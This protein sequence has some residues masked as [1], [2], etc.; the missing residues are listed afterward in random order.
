[1]RDARMSS[2][3]IKSIS[4]LC[5][6]HTYKTITCGENIDSC[7]KGSDPRI[8]TISWEDEEYEYVWY[9]ARVEHIALIQHDDGVEL[10][11]RTEGERDITHIYVY[12][13]PHYNDNTKYISIPLVWDAKSGEKASNQWDA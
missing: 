9:R 11:I 3:Q 13:Y 8:A 12:P 5:A 4:L 7:L 6:P 10:G 1:M 2:I